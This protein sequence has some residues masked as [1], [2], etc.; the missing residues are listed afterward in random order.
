MKEFNWNDELVMEFTR[1]STQGAYGIFEGCKSLE[2][3]L[4]K[5][6]E[7]YDKAMRY[8]RIEIPEDMD[9]S[10]IVFANKNIP[11][12]IDFN[13]IHFVGRGEV[14]LDGGLDKDEWMVKAYTG[15]KYF[16][17]DFSDYKCVV[18]G[19]LNY[20]YDEGQKKK[21]FTVYQLSLTKYSK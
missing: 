21:E 10:E 12:L 9:K 3:K 7:H 2:L 1:M 8:F 4:D 13:P 6:K 5:F 15:S 17:F 19:V 20:T 11:I 16:D 14:K 18:G